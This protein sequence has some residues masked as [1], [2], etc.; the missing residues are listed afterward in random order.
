MISAEAAISD[1]NGEW[2]VGGVE[3][4][5]CELYSYEGRGLLLSYPSSL[6]SGLEM[7]MMD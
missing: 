7:E 4:W 6:F 3:E 1:E 5:W 2:W